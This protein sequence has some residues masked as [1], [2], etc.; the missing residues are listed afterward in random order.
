VGLI[1]VSIVMLAVAW[2]LGQ[3]RAPLPAA[4]VLGIA[5]SAVPQLGA[6]GGLLGQSMDPR[7]F[8][9]G[10]LLGA[11]LGCLMALAA[12][13][14]PALF[15]ME[16]PLAAAGA[17]GVALAVLRADGTQAAAATAV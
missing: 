17:L 3:K 1:V 10:V 5:L 12:A 6:A 16:V 13:P 4:G 8:W 2:S 9:C 11:N 15:A 14:E 7:F